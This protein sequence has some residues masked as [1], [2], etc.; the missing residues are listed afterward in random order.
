MRKIRAGFRMLLTAAAAGL[1]FSGV[2]FAGGEGSG[3]PAGAYEPE[4]E[5]VQITIPEMKETHTLLWV[6]DMHI[7]SGAS[8]PDVTA[9]HREEAGERYEMMRNAASVP[10]EE[11][12]RALSRQ[13]DSY[14]ADY[15]IFGADMLD[16]F[17]EENLEKFREGTE[18]IQTPWMY[19]RADHDYGRWYSDMRIRKMRRLHRSVAPQN[20][21]WTARFEDF[22]VAGLDNTTTTISPETLEEFRLL[23]EEGLPV[24]LCTHVPF[25]SGEGDC[26]TLVTLSKQLWGDRVLCWGDGDL[27]DTSGGGCM[28]ELLDLIT[29]AD[30]PVCAVL[31]GHLHTSWEGQLTETCLQHVFSAAFEDHIGIITVSG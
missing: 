1:L 30:S 3:E 23:C 18:S 5:E 17:S 21:L 11:T 9:Q 2:C 26:G 10:A 6:S 24:I 15:V 19:L 25:D 7:C 8:D 13:I 27:Y 4:V 12:W 16:S 31:A 29:A 14:D 20:K 22:I 28:K